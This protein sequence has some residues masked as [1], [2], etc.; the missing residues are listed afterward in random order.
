MKELLLEV[1]KKEF[2]E[3]RFQDIDD[4]VYLRMLALN[5]LLAGGVLDIN[6]IW[7][8][9]GYCPSTLVKNAS[10]LGLDDDEITPE[11]YIVKWL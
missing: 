7:K 8:E 3:W 1:N 2:L 5:I 11:D 4:L 9:T 10:S 6:E